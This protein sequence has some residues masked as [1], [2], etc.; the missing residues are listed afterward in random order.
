MG[1]KALMI[2]AML[3]T[4]LDPPAIA[5]TG[6]HG[7]VT[8]RYRL[9]VQVDPA[10]HTLEA[11]AWIQHPPSSRFY[12]HRGLIA[13]QAMAD[14]KPIGFHRDELGSPLPYV[15]AGTAVVMDGTGFRELYVR[16]GGEISDTTFG[17]NLVTSDLVELSMFSA[18]YPVWPGLEEYEFELEANLPAGY[19]ATTNGVRRS[20]QDR[21][22]RRVSLWRSYAP[23]FDM[24]LV[25]SPALHELEGEHDGA[26]VEV[27]YSR[28][29]AGF[30]QSRVAS[31]AKVMG[32]LSA[33]YGPPKVAGML[34][35]VYSPRDGQ[36][37]MRIPLLVI[38]EERA[39]ADLDG[40]FGKERRFRDECHETAHFW[41]ML[42]DPATPD[43]WINEGLAE[44]SAFRLSEDEFGTAF[45]SLR[46]EE[47][48][49][50]ARACQ[51]ADAI[52]QTEGS[53]PDREANRYDKATLMFVAARSRFGEEPLDRLLRS[54]Y[55]RFAGTH[56]LTTA[57]FLEEART[58]IGREAE[59]FF[60]EELY[61]KGTMNLPA[62]VSRP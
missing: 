14:G 29:P 3:V 19:L 1:Y 4:M 59:G 33:L 50:N 60:R 62:P 36:G 26:K 35:L 42:A 56:E 23:G 15:P 8:M 37:Y 2:G 53:S 45:T 18:W 12:L 47:Y 41:W 11:E 61:R 55:A 58:R 48:R 51:T 49:Q 6:L 17:C 39:R 7:G 5:E 25:A 22:G 30:A 43:D 21:G 54:L 32:R 52:A 46:L 10:R 9:K 38:S 13:Q 34:R 24:V 57:R 27:Y 28:L 16:Y 44:Y 31:L 20:Q 40:Q